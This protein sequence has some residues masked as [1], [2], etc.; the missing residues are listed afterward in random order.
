MAWLV[1]MMFMS[2]ILE[3]VNCIIWVKQSRIE[4]Y[5]KIC[6]EFDHSIFV[7]TTLVSRH[8]KG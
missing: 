5:F 8:Q 3:P 7:R 6:C 1:A 4:V 2:A